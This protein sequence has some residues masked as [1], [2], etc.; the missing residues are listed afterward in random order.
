M[1][2]KRGRL[3]Y[4]ASAQHLTSSYF[5]VKKPPPPDFPDAV[6]NRPGF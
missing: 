1:P 5:K 4:A 2:T 6:V 3:G